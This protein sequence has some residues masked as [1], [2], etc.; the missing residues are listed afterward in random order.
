[1]ARQIA[2]D[3]D[4]DLCRGT[5]TKVCIEGS[6]SLEDVEGN[7]AF[8]GEGGQGFFVKPARALLELEQRGD[9]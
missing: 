7:A 9:Q 2:A 8:F 6:N 5:A 4:F 3:L 1:L